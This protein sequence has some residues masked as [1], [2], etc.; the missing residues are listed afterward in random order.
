MRLN[1]IDTERCVGCQSCMFACSRTKDRVGFTGSCIEVR[2]DGGVK[3]GFNVIVCKACDDP[4]CAKVCP[5]EALTPKKTGGVKLKKSLCN[6]C[7][8]CVDACILG[9]VFWD[10]ELNKPAICIQCGF[11]AEFCPHGVLAISEK[12]VVDAD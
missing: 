7:G 6:G 9:A 3:N 5:T 2:S 11:C 4:V 1:V 8:H 12:E 10:D